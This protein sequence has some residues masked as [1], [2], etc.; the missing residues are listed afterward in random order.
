MTMRV[1]LAVLLVVLAGCTSLPRTPSDSALK[2]YEQRVQIATSIDS[3]NIRGRIGYRA[4]D[5]GGTGTL[6]WNR[7]GGN[8]EIQLFDSLG[9]NRIIVRQTPETAYLQDFRGNEVTGQSASQLLSE[10]TGWYIPFNKM[11]DWVVAVAG[12]D[13]VDQIGINRGGELE[14]LKQSGWTLGYS[15]YKTVGD[16]HLPTRYRITSDFKIR[17]PRAKNEDL[18]ENY[19]SIRLSVREWGIQ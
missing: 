12:E 5:E 11:V 15:R 7:D 13:A 6:I 19:V 4:G 8:H 10:Q 18:A 16:Y 17:N 14:T 2:I 1:L 3:W 9:Q